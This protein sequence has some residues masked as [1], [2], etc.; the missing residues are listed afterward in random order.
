MTCICRPKCLAS[1]WLLPVSAYCSVCP[2][3]SRSRIAPH[4][5][6]GSGRGST[7]SGLIQSGQPLIF[8]RRCW[9]SSRPR[10]ISSL[11]ICF[12]AVILIFSLKLEY[13]SL[14]MSFDNYKSRN[15]PNKFWVAIFA[16]VILGLL[17]IAEPFSAAAIAAALL[18]YLA[19]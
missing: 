16:I 19:A 2:L 18:F 8:R 11:V 4:G 5:S 10:S 17:V 12:F 3:F 9:Y 15:K 7:A 13:Y 6:D 14:S 1:S